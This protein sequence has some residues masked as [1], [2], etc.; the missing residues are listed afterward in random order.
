M[1]KFWCQIKCILL[2]IKG[3]PRVDEWIFI[4][5]SCAGMWLSVQQRVWDVIQKKLIQTSSIHN[6]QGCDFIFGFQWLF[7]YAQFS[8]HLHFY[9]VHDHL[10][11]FE[12]NP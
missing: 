5:S 4:G 11:L 12:S 2:H 3:Q 10:S 8:I 6:K 1:Y 9:Q 7:T